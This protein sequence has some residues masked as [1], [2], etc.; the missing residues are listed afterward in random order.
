VRGGRERERSIFTHTLKIV[1]FL[2]LYKF[3]F[4]LFLHTHTFF[5][6]VNTCVS[7]IRISHFINYNKHKGSY[8]YKNLETLGAA[9]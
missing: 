9:L 5:T 2:F 6:A 4:D 1:T 8:I 7:H 3:Y